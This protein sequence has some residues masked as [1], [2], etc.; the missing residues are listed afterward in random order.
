[1]TPAELFDAVNTANSVEDVARAVARFEEV[2]GA[3]V[4]WTPFGNRDNNRGTIEA[5]ADPG[6]SLVERLTNGIDAVLEDEFEKH[7]GTPVCR[8]PKEAATAWLNIPSGGLSE[9]TPAQRRA[10]A[11]RVSIKLKSAEDRAS[12]IVEVRD[13]GTGLLPDEMP[14][15]ILSLNES[16]KVQKHYLAGAYG[17]G[18]SSTLATSK[19][20]FFAS[21]RE[22]G[23]LVGFTIACYQDLPAD[24]FKTG[25]YVYLTYD[26]NVLTVQKSIAEFPTGTLVKHFGYDL[27]NYPSPLGPNSIY[28]LLNQTMFDPVLPVWLDDH[29]IHGYRRVIKGSRNAL[30]GAV[31][32]GDAEQRGPSLSHSVRQFYTNIADYG[33]IGIEYWVLERPTVANKK[34]IAAF[35]N[36]AKPIV[37]TINGQNHAEMSQLIVRK[38]AE[39]P[40]LS[41]RL[42]CHVD[43]NFL[44]PDAKRSLFVSNREDARRGIV[45]DLIYKE[46]V[47]ALRSDDDL[48]RL[49]NEAR[50]QGMRERDETAVQQMRTEVARLLRL[51]GVNV[52]V[53]AAEAS[54]GQGERNGHTTGGGRRGPRHP[55]PIELHEPPTYIKIVWDE[56]EE[57]GFYPQQRRY[58]RIETDANSDYH[59]PSNP[60]ASRINVIAPSE[61]LV[62]RGSTP[63]SGGRMRAIFEAKND[64]A[65]GSQGTIR[66]E[67]SRPGHKMLVDQRTFKI[68]EAPPA[69]TTERYITLPPFRVEPV[70]GPDD[71]LWA[72]LGWPD[73]INSVASSAE[74]DNGTLVIYY[75]KV[76]PKYADRVAV[77]ERRDTAL[78]SSFTGR[79]EIWLAVHSLLL[80]QDQQQTATEAQ[81]SQP[82]EDLEVEET[83][84]RQ[85]RCRLATMASMVAA[86]EIQSAPQAAEGD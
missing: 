14:R 28:G 20:V 6:R 15:T 12:R 17:Q 64:A 76:F 33:R 63:L 26:G 71:Q 21:R 82:T 38:D 23:T 9:M 50:E 56:N 27:T 75:S 70:G 69:R 2:N 84:E 80:H 86:R 32:E 85:E 52:G 45:Y 68:V 41:Q 10:V 42:I 18:G 57:I 78:A 58:I 3:R 51:Q 81:R 39:L 73:N 54:S 61:G 5:S 43:C 48:A 74:M 55:Q 60:S 34:P 79:Y 67:L 22:Q 24:L 66:V 40:Y 19:Y 25:R 72:E 16:N 31:D 1:M 59:N 65:V 35:V 36:P 46:I 13:E 29:E 37:L 30:N 44:T 77:F 11:R 53:G 4:Q 47:K 8:T 49:N 7:H 83:R 62:F